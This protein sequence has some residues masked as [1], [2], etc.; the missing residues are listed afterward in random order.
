MAEFGSEEHVRS[1]SREQLERL[2]RYVFNSRKGL[3]TIITQQQREV[4]ELRRKVANQAAQLKAVQA[5]LERRNRTLDKYRELVQRMAP[6]A[7][8]GTEKLCPSRDC[9]MFE[10]CEATGDERCPA[11]ERMEDMLG[12]IGGVSDAQ[13]HDVSAQ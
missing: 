12:E 10:E 3:E 5:A 8:Y 4:T 2:F 7:L 13:L 1:L 6:F 9:F 11:E